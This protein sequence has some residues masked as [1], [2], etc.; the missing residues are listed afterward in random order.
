MR[1]VTLVVSVVAG[2]ATEVV[3]MAVLIGGAGGGGVGG[4]GVTASEMDPEA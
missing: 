3:M 4:E 2:I 1:G